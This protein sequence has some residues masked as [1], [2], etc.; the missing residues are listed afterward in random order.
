[1]KIAF[2]HRTYV[3]YT[4]DTPYVSPLGGSESAICYTAVELAKMGHEVS[5]LTSTGEPGRYR[6]VE[7]LNYKTALTA[8]FLN[9]QDIIVVS[10]EAC[11][12][13][14]RDK[15]QAKKPDRKSTRLNSSHV[16]ESR[17]PSSA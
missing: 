2:L 16:S 6:N 5:L 10:N 8:D 14:L 11:G 3:A 9:R 13:E 12:R 17:M 15:F 7:C 1:M 4:V